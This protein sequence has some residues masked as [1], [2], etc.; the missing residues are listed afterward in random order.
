MSPVN[1]RIYSA[2]FT[3]TE[4][5]KL[6]HPPAISLTRI[7]L[8]PTTCLDHS[9]TC[10][11]NFY[12]MRHAITFGSAHDNGIGLPEKRQEFCTS[13]RYRKSV[14]AC[15]LLTTRPWWYGNA[16]Q[17]IN[18]RPATK[19]LSIRWVWHVV[20]V[21]LSHPLTPVE[22]V[23]EW[24]SERASERAS[25]S[26]WVSEWVSQSVSQSVNVR[27]SGMQCQSVSQ[28][29]AVS[30]VGSVSQVNEWASTLSD[31]TLVMKNSLYIFVCRKSLSKQ[32]PVNSLTYMYAIV[33]I[34][35]LTFSRQSYM[36]PGT[37]FMVTMCQKKGLPVM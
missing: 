19:L 4:E 3:L 24:V 13:F 36:W 10:Q 16:P 2:L 6:R 12:S 26:E 17:N 9:S 7:S 27:Q 11:T 31:M 30:Q 21:W 34:L 14:C 35:I 25:V 29:Q 33:F 1:S 32:W 8:S 20:P 23:S 28:C 18:S 15:F 22:W 5:L 37:K